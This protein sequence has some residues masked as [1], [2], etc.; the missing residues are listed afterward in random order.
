MSGTSGKWLR[1]ETAIAGAPGA[2]RGPAGAFP[3]RAQANAAATSGAPR[4]AR[5]RGMVARYT[6]TFTYAK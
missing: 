2:G 5:P 3:G 6:A 4:K 1:E